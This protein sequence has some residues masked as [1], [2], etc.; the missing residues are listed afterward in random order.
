MQYVQRKLQRS[1]TEIRRSR[2]SRPKASRSAGRPAGSAIFAGDDVIGATV[3][4]VVMQKLFQLLTGGGDGPRPVTDYTL[5]ILRY[6]GHCGRMLGQ[7][8]DWIVTEPA[9]T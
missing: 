6:L 5:V 1:V 9:P 3:S 8:E 7:P 2:S 4:L